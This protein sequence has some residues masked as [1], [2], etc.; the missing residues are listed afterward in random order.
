[1]HVNVS[2]RTRVLVGNAPN[3][4]RYSYVA[5]FKMQA[6]SCGGGSVRRSLSS[7][8]PLAKR[9][10]LAT[11]SSPSDEVN[12]MGYAHLPLLPSFPTFQPFPFINFHSSPESMAAAQHP[13]IVR[14]AKQWLLDTKGQRFLDASSH[15]ALGKVREIQ[16]HGPSAGPSWHALQTP[17]RRW[18]RGAVHFGFLGW[19][20]D[21]CVYRPSPQI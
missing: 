5:S 21:P 14:G 1:M 3:R 16:L 10:K 7:D 13:T 17:P 19:A 12:G 15:V 9:L 4:G 6:V 18:G 11:D 8:T 2:C 20:G